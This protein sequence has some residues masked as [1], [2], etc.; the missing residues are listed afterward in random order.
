MTDMSDIKWFES[1]QTLVEVGGFLVHDKGVTAQE[2]L[3]FF[4]KPWKYEDEWAESLAA[5]EAGG[6]SVSFDASAL[7]KILEYV[8]TVFRKGAS[9]EQRQV[10]DMR[11]TEVYG[12]PHVY[13]GEIEGVEKI[14][15]H[16]IIVGVD[17]AKAEA[18]R[19][20]VVFLLNHYPEPDRLKGGPSYIEVGG[21]LGSQEHAFR[22]F[23]LGQVLGLWS[24]ITPALLHIEGPE[25]DALA[26]GGMILID[27]YRPEAVTK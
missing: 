20:Q 1:H 5:R 12:Y 24:V 22:L 11:V 8:T 6:G 25:A 10:G 9:V 27:G 18:V 21:A 15:C 26:G 16:F 13:D 17:K 2:L 3:D 19:G 14:D 23:A 4:E 7:N